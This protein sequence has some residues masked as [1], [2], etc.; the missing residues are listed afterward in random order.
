MEVSMKIKNIAIFFLAASLLICIPGCKKASDV[1]PDDAIGALTDYSACKKE[2]WGKQNS[3]LERTAQEDQ[4]CIEYEYNG[5]NTLLINHTN[6][7]FNCCPGNILAD[8][9][10]SEG[11]IS[12]LEKETEHGCKCLCYFDLDFRLT[13]IPPGIYTIRITCEGGLTREFTIDLNAS[14][15]GSKCWDGRLF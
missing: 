4:E 6:A 3:T 8:I 14:L 15:Y 10:F 13:H 9:Q 11:L 12:I 2:F 5:G 7:V 1:F